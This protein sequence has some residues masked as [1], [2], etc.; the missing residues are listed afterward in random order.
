MKNLETILSSFDAVAL[1]FE[2]PDCGVCKALL[3][4]IQELF[5]EEFPKIELVCI[6]IS[7]DAA[8]AASCGVFSAATLVVYFDKK[9][10]IRKS[11]AISI[12]ALQSEVSRIYTMFFE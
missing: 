12:S 11:R 8:L 5:D 2:G 9:E 3:P 7:K 6:D 1:Y 4:K 10:Y